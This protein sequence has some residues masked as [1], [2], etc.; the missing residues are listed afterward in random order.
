MV[1]LLLLVLAAG[2]YAL[3][4]A[5]AFRLQGLDILGSGVPPAAEIWQWGDLVAGQHLLATRPASIAA[6]IERHP[7]V[8]SAH[9]RVAMPGRLV[10][11]IEH[12]VGVALVPHLTGFWELDAEG[13]VLDWH[14]TLARRALP[15]ITGTAGPEVAVGEHWSAS[16]AEPLLALAAGLG[17]RRGAL[18]EIHAAGDQITA[19]T[20]AGVVVLWGDAGD[21]FAGKLEVLDAFLADA[22]PGAVYLDLRVTGRPVIGR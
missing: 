14:P 6:A 2:G 16:E 12:R 11:D 7:Y 4:E 20:V 13:W 22:E 17:A 10:V 8:R 3:V 18:S 19:Y 21:G 1:L 5:P 9:V 15:I